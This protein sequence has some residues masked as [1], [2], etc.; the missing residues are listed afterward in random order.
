MSH[1]RAPVDWMQHA[2]GFVSFWGER[3]AV[4]GDGILHA[5]QARGPPQHARPRISFW[6]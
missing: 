6:F 2:K 1:M 4:D 5:L 3:F